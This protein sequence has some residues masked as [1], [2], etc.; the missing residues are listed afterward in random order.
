M[1]HEPQKETDFLGTIQ[2]QEIHNILHNSHNV[3]ICFVG[4][5]GSGKTSLGDYFTNFYK[6]KTILF[7]SNFIKSGNNFKEKINI[8]KFQ[9]LVKSCIVF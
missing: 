9:G 7:D 3:N 6:L 5:S 1:F 4:N 2:F 8:L